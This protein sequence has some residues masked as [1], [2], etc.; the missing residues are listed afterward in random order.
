MMSLRFVARAWPL[1]LAV[2]GASSSGTPAGRPHLA[3]SPRLA[4]SGD[5]ALALSAAPASVS[6]GA[7]VYLLRGNQFV[8]VRDGTNG[9][10]CL[11]N[12]DPRNKSVSPECFDP[13]AA[14][15]LMQEEMMEAQLVARGM[16]NQAIE[17]EID[18][19]YQSGKLHYP[20][21]GGVI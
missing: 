5:V 17:H 11:V 12:R 18:A 14:R 6:A 21:H 2:L 13:E 7:S 15:T 19:A 20:E 1:M 3:L 10:A 8:K 16:N 4:D 9:F